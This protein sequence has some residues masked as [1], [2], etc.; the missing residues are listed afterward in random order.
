MTS[1]VAPARRKASVLGLEGAPRAVCSS[2][3]LTLRSRAAGSSRVG[4]PAAA[5]RS[6]L[7]AFF[8]T[9]ELRPAAAGP[10]GEGDEQ[11][12]DELPGRLVGEPTLLVELLPGLADHHARLVQHQGVENPQIPT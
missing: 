11:L 12:A 4:L 2:A 6:T 7:S 1:P 5:V 10:L 3:R 8:A 9:R